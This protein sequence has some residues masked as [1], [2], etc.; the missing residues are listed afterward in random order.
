M[1]MKA[2]KLLSLLIVL[3]LVSGLSITAFAEEKNEIL[4]NAFYIEIP[5]EFENYSFYANCY[6]L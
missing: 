1:I 4:N 5:E 3:V 6:F 2:K